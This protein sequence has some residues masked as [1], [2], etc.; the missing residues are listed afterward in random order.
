MCEEANAN[1]FLKA[2]VNLIVSNRLA[3]L[4]GEKKRAQ[5]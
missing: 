1:F 4:L 3:K 2:I 5:S